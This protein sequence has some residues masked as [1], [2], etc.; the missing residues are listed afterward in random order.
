MKPEQI[1]PEY[2]F[3]VLA[4]AWAASVELGA[5][6]FFLEGRAH[7]AGHDSPLER[8]LIER[9]ALLVA[10]VRFD[11][12]PHEAFHRDRAVRALAAADALRRFLPAALRS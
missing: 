9:G 12:D 2:E 10:R 7:I 5:G 4:S 6:I 1:K 8:S 11:R 3:P